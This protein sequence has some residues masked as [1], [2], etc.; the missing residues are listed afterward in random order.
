MLSAEWQPFCSSLDA[1]TAASDTD[2]AIT[3]GTHVDSLPG[4]LNNTVK[5]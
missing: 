5:L 1:S 4:L 2:W 3:P